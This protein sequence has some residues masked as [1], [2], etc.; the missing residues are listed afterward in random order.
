[1]AAATSRQ[2][3]LARHVE[4]DKNVADVH[5]S[6]H[7]NEISPRGHKQLLRLAQQLMSGIGNMPT[8]VVAT[9]SSQAITSAKLL[10]ELLR[11][12]YE[13]EM[14]LSPIDLGAAAGKSNWELRAA[15]PESFASIDLFRNRVISASELR[16][17]GAEEVASTESRLLRWWENEGRNRCPGKL[18]V[19]SNSTVL[20]ISHFLNGILP[21]DM[22][23]RYLGLPNG[24]FRIWR[25]NGDQWTAAPAFPEHTWPDV[26]ITR[27][28]SRSGSIAITRSRP[29][30]VPRSRGIVV[31]PGYFG[32]SRHGPYGLYSRMARAWA[33]E[34]YETVCLDPLGS[35]DSTPTFRTFDTEVESVE[36]VI[37]WLSNRVG[38]LVVAGHS[39]GGATALQASSASR[40]VNAVWCL[41]PLCRFE[42]LSGAFFS[43]A[44]VS[45]ILIAGRTYRH[46]LELRMDFIDESGAAW[47]RHNQNVQALWLAEEDPYA[48][49]M[50]FPGISQERI[51]SV[52]GADH[53]FSTNGSA[54][55]LV[56]STINNLIDR[57]A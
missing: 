37:R 18:V 1:M 6:S 26:Q 39:M 8:A 7:L 30:W 13:G 43:P 4:T 50:G 22:R 53:N 47:E 23:Y 5:G 27:L 44:Q 17:L 21:T 41:A 36:T 9:P 19:G 29:S 42:D 16:I 24:S 46:G 52:P 2:I 45:E 56:E 20:M 14:S 40:N 54:L 33:W 10:A 31:V 48:Q 15:H 49:G 35:G 12:P 55:H 28:P 32:S 57:E 3:I 11:I 25:G 51:H 34:G 38:S